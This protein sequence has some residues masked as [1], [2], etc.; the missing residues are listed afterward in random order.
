MNHE[1]GTMLILSFESRASDEQ[2]YSFTLLLFAVCQHMSQYETQIY[3]AIEL[4]QSPHSHSP[5][6]DLIY[7]N[8]RT[9]LDLFAR[10]TS[11]IY[12]LGTTSGKRKR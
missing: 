12:V 8:S 7:W 6:F 1:A 4:I 10:R 2:V 9:L 5:A 11:S 3:T